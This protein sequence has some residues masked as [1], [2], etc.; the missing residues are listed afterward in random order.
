MGFTPIPRQNGPRLVPL[1]LHLIPWN[2][3]SAR[4]RE[5]HCFP[6]LGSPGLQN[7]FPF[8]PRLFLR[9]LFSKVDQQLMCLVLR[10]DHGVAACRGVWS[11]H[12]QGARTG[13][14][15]RTTVG[16]GPGQLCV[17]MQ[18]SCHSPAPNAKESEIPPLNPAQQVVMKVCV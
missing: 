14:K 8:G 11:L 17:H 13:V 16:R 3:E 7:S 1:Q 2:K 18:P 10:S 6:M 5:H 15:Q 12:R 4:P 9:C